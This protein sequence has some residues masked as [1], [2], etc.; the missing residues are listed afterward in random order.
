M[1][2]CSN[3]HI[4]THA[5]SFSLF[6]HHVSSNTP[7]LPQISEGRQYIERLRY[8]FQEI[9]RAA[10]FGAMIAMRKLFCGSSFVCGEMLLE[11]L[12]FFTLCKSACTRVAFLC[13]WDLDMFLAVFCDIFMAGADGVLR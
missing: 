9:L 2:I 10:L 6:P 1:E 13:L 5:V 11:R 4:R 12:W 7:F 3:L 8:F